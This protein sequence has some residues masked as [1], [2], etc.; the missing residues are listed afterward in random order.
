[1]TASVQ[2]VKNARV[3]WDSLDMSGQENE[4][5]LAFQCDELP[6]EVFNVPCHISWPGLFKYSI[7]HKGYLAYGEGL[8][9][10]AIWAKKGTKD[11]PLT[12][13]KP[14]VAGNPAYFLKSGQMSYSPKSA[15][16]ALPTFD[17]SM[18]PTG[19]TVVRGV[20]LED[21]QVA[22]A[23]TG[24]GTPRQVGATLAGQRLYA[25]LH[26]LAVTGVNPTV[27]VIVESDSLEA[28]DTPT[29][30]FTFTQAIAK[31]S[32]FAVPV[33]APV[34]DDWY[35]ASITLSVGATAKIVVAV[36]VEG[37]PDPV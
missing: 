33:E 30:R 20:L 23:A 6:G 9:E 37:I 27:D 5:G 14:G 10:E 13:S 7:S 1:M 15:I 26:I 24:A 16:G 2:V 3:W 18:S 31:G 35:R 21:A 25:I 32:Q 17:M 22:K 36:G 11:V 29:T 4:L 12:L 19:L 34:A 8:I 28:F